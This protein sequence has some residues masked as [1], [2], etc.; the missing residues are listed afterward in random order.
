MGKVGRWEWE[1]MEPSPAIEN[2]ERKED[3]IRWLRVIAV[4]DSRRES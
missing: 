4:F 3:L 2:A 1:Q